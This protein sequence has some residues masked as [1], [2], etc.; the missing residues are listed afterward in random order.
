MVR[1]YNI[2]SIFLIIFFI[3]TYAFDISYGSGTPIYYRQG[4]II[5]N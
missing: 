1:P 3:D 5:Y 4:K 2:M